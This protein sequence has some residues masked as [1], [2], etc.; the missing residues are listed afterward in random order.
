MKNK[1]SKCRFYLTID[2]EEQFLNEMCA[3]GWKPTKIILGCIFCFERCEPDEYIARVA[4]T[5]EAKGKTHDKLN[6]MK[7]ALID[8]GAEII[9]ETLNFDTESRIY[10]IRKSSLGEFEINTDKESLIADYT[11]RIRMHIAMTAVLAVMVVFMLAF[12]IMCLFMGVPESA[13]IEFGGV[14]F[15]LVLAIPCAIPIFKYRKLIKKLKSEQ[16]FSE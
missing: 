3:K 12:G 1:T 6:F 13:G 11:S 2:R 16:E 8:S 4:C 15:E 14:I 5:K 10:A 9:P 7:E